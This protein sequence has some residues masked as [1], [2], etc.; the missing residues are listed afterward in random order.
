MGWGGG[1]R[2]QDVDYF[3]CL[4]VIQLLENI[5]RE[6]GSA[7]LKSFFGSYS[8]SQLRAWD[9]IAK[10]FAKD[11]VTSFSLLFCF[12]M[13]DNNKNKTN[14]QTKIKV[15]LGDASRLLSQNVNFEM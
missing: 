2:A 9:E 8:S 15:F 1:G 10:A 14:K 12:V 6:S 3:V 5:E 4:N 7:N 11:N 13:I